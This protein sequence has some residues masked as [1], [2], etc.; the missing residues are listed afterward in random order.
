MKL[1]LEIPETAFSALR[2]PPSQFGAELRLAACVKWY[3]LGLLSQAKASEIAAVSRATFIDA[4]RAY[5]VPA[6]QI[7]R[8]EL[9]GELAL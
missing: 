8:G 2:K 3:E 1:T 9:E 7:E 6:I 4:L 5:Q